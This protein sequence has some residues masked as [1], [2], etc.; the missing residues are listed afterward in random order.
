MQCT[1]RDDICTD[2]QSGHHYDCLHHHLTC[3]VQIFIYMWPDESGWKTIPTPSGFKPRNAPCWHIYTG[4]DLHDEVIFVGRHLD[5][6]CCPRAFD[7]MM[8]YCIRTRGGLYSLLPIS[9]RW[10]EPGT[11]PRSGTPQQLNTSI[12]RCDVFYLQPFFSCVF[13]IDAPTK[14]AS[15]FGLYNGFTKMTSSCTWVC[16]PALSCTLV[17]QAAPGSACRPCL[18]H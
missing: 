7:S 16:L 14:V 2:T 5:Q 17:T 10:N 15:F 1:Y 18:V 3:T 8:M 13:L 4:S 9:P 12:L 6:T 11:M